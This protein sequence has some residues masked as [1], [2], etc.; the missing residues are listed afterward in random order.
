MQAEFIAARQCL[1]AFRKSEQAARSCRRYP[2]GEDPVDYSCGPQ[3]CGQQ[4]G[5]GEKGDQ[6]PLGTQ[7]ETNRPPVALDPRDAAEYLGP[8]DKPVDFSR[9]ISFD[10]KRTAPNPQNAMQK[11]A[12]RFE[13][14]KGNH[15][16]GANG[17]GF[18]RR[19]GDDVLV[20]DERIH[21]G[22]P[23]SESDR[24]SP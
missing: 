24:D 2:G 4:T 6:T 9:I 8:K 12:I 7:A 5:A 20:P 23:G 14:R 1:P 17:R 3:H 18:C 11:R 21:A 15:V 19:N 10:K 13:V 16:T 22:A